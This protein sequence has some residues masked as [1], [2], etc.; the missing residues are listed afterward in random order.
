MSARNQPITL[1]GQTVAPGTRATIDLPVAK[2]YTHDRIGMPVQVVCGRQAGPRLF[3]SA[4][5]H[6]DEINGVEVIRRLLKLPILKR[7]HGTLIAIPIVNVH[8]FIYHSRYL[9]DGRDLNRSFPG[10]ESGSLTARVANLF[11]TEIVEQCSHGIDLH[12]GAGHRT[13]LPHVRANLDDPET[14]RLAHAFGVPLLLNSNLRDGSLRQT[15]AER[16]VPMLL[17]EGGE[18]LRFDEV[19]IRAGMRGIV[20]V[21]RALE[22]L[23]RSGHKP[24]RRIEPVIARSSTWVRAPESGIL[25]LLAPLGARVKKNGLL[26]V[27]ANPF[28]DRE[29]EVF[30]PNDGIVLGRT[31]L[32]LV[33]EGDALYHM[34][35][36]EQVEQAAQNVDLFQEVHTPAIPEAPDPES[37]IP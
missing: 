35:R 32:P 33:N 30:S 34:A 18:A 4:A 1:N 24:A 12:T 23:P 31:N 20:N 19:A 10:S 15:A 3:V 27:I 14:S 37:P 17:Y 7:L 25:R 6:G 21:M 29:T 16:G 26:G 5:M 9:P 11:M 2:L 28:G 8:G 22:M 36:F 13:N